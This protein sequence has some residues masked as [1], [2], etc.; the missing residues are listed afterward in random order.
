M[1]KLDAG[2][3]MIPPP[4][5]QLMV[6]DT[7]STTVTVEVQVLAFPDKS[8]TVSVTEFAPMFAQLN[9]DCDNV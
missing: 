5:L 1:S 8:V 9:E 3:M 4:V 2:P 7:V 6:G